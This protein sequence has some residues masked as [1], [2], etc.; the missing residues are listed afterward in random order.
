MLWAEIQG[1]LG[2]LSPL[3]NSYEFEP[4]TNHTQTLSGPVRK[5]TAFEIR[6]NYG[7]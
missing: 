4:V 2:G 3:P 6:W 1:F 7:R 5:K